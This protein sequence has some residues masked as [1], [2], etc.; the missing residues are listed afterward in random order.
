VLA[1]GLQVSVLLV[2]FYVLHRTRIWRRL[3]DDDGG[4]DR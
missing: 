4:E 1:V 3:R 2:A